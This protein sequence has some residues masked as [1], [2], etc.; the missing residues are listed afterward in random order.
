MIVMIIRVRKGYCGSSTT[1]GL[2]GPGAK[3]NG[4]AVLN[5]FNNGP[6]AV[7]RR[8]V[9]CATG[10][11]E[12]RSTVKKREKVAGG[13]KSQ[14]KVDTNQRDRRSKQ[15]LGRYDH[16]GSQRLLEGALK[17]CARLWSTEARSDHL[18]ASLAPFA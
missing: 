14:Y 6:L 10:N 1:I 13:G 7:K 8:A 17:T 3:M 18:F 12:E 2:K 9:D 15:R 11:E 16:S 5:P 4:G